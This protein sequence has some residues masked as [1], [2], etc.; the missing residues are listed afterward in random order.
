MKKIIGEIVKRGLL[1]VP[2]GIAITYAIPF[3]IS[4]CVGDGKFYPVVPAFMQQCANELQAVGIQ[5]GMGSLMGFI[6]GCAG[7]VWSQD[8]WSL[9]LQTF[10]HFLLLCAGY[11]PAAWVCW[12]MNHTVG[13]VLLYI[14]IFSAGY[15]IVWIV[16]ITLQFRELK[17]I[18]GKC[19]QGGDT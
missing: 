2:I 18:N 7:I 13:N 9:A 16:T 10:V 1:G 5:L 19:K 17:Q 8:Q 3:I 4:V 11:I 14:G 6:F 12:W 15:A